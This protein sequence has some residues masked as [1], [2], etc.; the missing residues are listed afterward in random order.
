MAT[1][2]GTLSFVWDLASD[3]GGWRGRMIGS[4]PVG[5][6]ELQNISVSGDDVAFETTA[7]SPMGSVHLAFKGSVVGDVMK[8]ACKTR[9]G[10]N[11]FSAIRG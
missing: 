1:P 6:S 10:D 3:N 9:F 8:G 4:G 7:Q 2:I 5:D 11:S